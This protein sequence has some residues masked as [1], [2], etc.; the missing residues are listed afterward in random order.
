[1]SNFKKISASNFETNRF[2]QLP[3]FLFED[4]FFAKMS[5]DS[6]VM[7]SILKDR[8]E[9]SRKNN[10]IDKEGNIYL[11][12][13]NKQLC[14]ILDYSEPKII[15]L[16]KE[17]ESFNLITNERQGLNKPNKIYLLEPSYNTELK[18]FKFKNKRNLSSRTKENL[19]QEQKNF[20]SNDNKYRDTNIRDNENSDTDDLNDIENDLFN[21][22]TIKFYILD[23]LPAKIGNYLANFSITDI[24]IIKK[25]I[26]KAKSSFNKENNTV[27]RLEDFEEELLK[28]IKRFKAIQIEKKEDVINMQGYLMKSIKNELEETHSLYMRRKNIN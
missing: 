27:Y 24:K 26:L 10:W 25:V 5:T 17:L 4:S 1:M 8:F 23:E 22:N 18:N 28:T 6:K 9:L 11:L 19:V 12:Y 7:Y 2:Y 13:T 3:K 14:K 20:K 15:K 21:Q 16:K